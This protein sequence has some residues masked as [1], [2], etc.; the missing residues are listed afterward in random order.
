MILFIKPSTQIK[1]K[2]NPSTPINTIR[3]QIIGT[4]TKTQINY[5]KH[6]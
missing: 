6:K 3:T 5:N 1:L 2:T 4:E